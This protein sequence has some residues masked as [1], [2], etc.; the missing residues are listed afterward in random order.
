MKKIT[1]EASN[2]RK[3]KMVYQFLW[4]YKPYNCEC[5]EVS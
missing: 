3:K 4:F 1:I 5:S 2:K